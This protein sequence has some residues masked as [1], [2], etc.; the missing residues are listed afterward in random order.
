MPRAG[1]SAPLD[2]NPRVGG[3]ATAA[4]TGADFPMNP[5]GVTSAPGVDIRLFR[6]SDA[7]RI[8]PGLEAAWNELRQGHLDAAQRAYQQLEQRQPANLDVQLGLGRL[9]A[10]QGVPEEARRHY[11]R[12]LELDPR[13]P[14]ARAG[15][16]VL[17]P[18]DG[19]HALDSEIRSQAPGEP[20]AQLA[21]AAH[22]SAAGQW[23]EAEQA[24]FEALNGH[25]G[26]P[27]LLYNLAIALDHLGQSAAARRHYQ[28]ALDATATRPAHFSRPQ[29]EQR[30]QALSA[31]QGGAR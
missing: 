8:D 1:V 4:A 24:W 31:S 19:D 18:G 6:S 30:I 22:L 11:R 16:A 21:L 28:E 2:R 13:N 29:V 10:E 23:P 9:A 5:A 7:P 12:A 15:L 26:D 14:T 25:P 17:A 3:N 27:D 20:D